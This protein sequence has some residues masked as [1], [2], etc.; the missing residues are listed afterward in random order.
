MSLA[1]TP[2]MRNAQSTIGRVEVHYLNNGLHR[3]KK[4]GET[5]GTLQRCGNRWTTDKANDH[6][7]T[8][9]ANGIEALIRWWGMA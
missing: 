6:S 9:M 1:P 4:N 8:T 3:I 2:S 5:L 7:H